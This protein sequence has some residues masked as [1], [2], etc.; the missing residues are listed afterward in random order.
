MNRFLFANP[1]FKLSQLDKTSECQCVKLEIVGGTAKITLS[2]VCGKVSIAGSG[3]RFIFAT[4]LTNLANF[5]S[6]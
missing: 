2:V 3:N 6:N 5:S 1:V 4:N